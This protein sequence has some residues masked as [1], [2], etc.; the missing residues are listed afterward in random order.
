MIQS[1]AWDDAWF[2]A[3]DGAG[4]ALVVRDKNAPVS[5]WSSAAQWA[6]HPAPGGSPG[7][8]NGSAIAWQFEGWRHSWFTPAQLADPLVT[9]PLGSAAG[10][11]IP[12]Q[13]RYA[14]GLNPTE[15]TAALLR[16][17]FDGG[18]LTA[19]FRRLQNLLDVQFTIEASSDAAA[20]DAVAAPMTA[21]TDH[22]DGTELVTVRDREPVTGHRFLRLRV[23]LARP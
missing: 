17:S 21:I 19:T 4:Y 16:A 1:F 23:T 5:A 6:I 15:P 9:G 7:A 3:A 14:L 10:D 11:G 13:L 20:W 8:A 2:P 12:N 22:G 18:Q